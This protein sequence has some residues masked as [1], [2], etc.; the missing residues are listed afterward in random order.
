[1][2]VMVE[3]VVY[4]DVVVA[5]FFVVGKAVTERNL[6]PTVV[7]LAV[8]RVGGDAL[9]GDDRHIICYVI[10]AAGGREEQCCCGCQ[11]E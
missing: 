2:G 11:T 1:M 6:V 10:V 8:Y 4:L 9:I 5:Q 3:I 7:H